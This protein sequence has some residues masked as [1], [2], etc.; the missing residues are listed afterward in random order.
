MQ[1]PCPASESSHSRWPARVPRWR[2]PRPRRWPSSAA[3]TPARAS[4]LG[5]RGD[6]RQGLPVHGHADR[7]RHG[8]HRRALRRRSPG[9]PASRRRGLPAAADRGLHRLQQARPGR[10]GPG[11]ARDRAPGLH[12]LRR[13]RHLDPEA[14]ARLDQG[15]DAG[16]RR[17]RDVA[18]GARRRSRRS[19]ASA[20]PRR[21]ATRPTRSRR[22][23]SRS[24][25]TPTARTPTTPSRPRRRSAPATPRAASTP[26]R[27]TRAARCSAATPPARCASWARRATAR[28]ARGPASPGV[29]ARV[30]D[31]TLR[32]WIRQQAPNGVG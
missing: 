15:A 24:R 31:T 7:A 9:R 29:Y 27:A 13:L 22:R 8:P 1:P 17:G 11:L 6:H 20:P 3:P 28:A 10:E 12:A 32:E 5:L 16:R 18:V 23:R 14:V 26:A 4:S 21:A 2:S 30:G 25:P 19:P